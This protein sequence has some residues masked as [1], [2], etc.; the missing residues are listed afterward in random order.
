MAKQINCTEHNGNKEKMNDYQ[1]Q[2]YQGTILRI[3]AVILLVCGAYE[4]L[5]KENNYMLLESSSD[6]FYIWI[7]FGLLLLVLGFV[8][9][10]D[11]KDRIPALEAGVQGEEKVASYLNELSDEYLILNNVSIQAK[12]KQTEI[13]SLVVSRY[14]VWVIET[15]N[16]SGYLTG[17]ANAKKWQRER[18]SQYG[19]I[20]QDEVNN[21]LGQ[22]HR[23]IW[24]LKEVLKAN[25]VYTHIHG[26]VILPSAQQVCVDSDEVVL[27][28][29]DL[30]EEIESERRVNLSDKDLYNILNAFGLQCGE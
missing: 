13:D 28:K 29:E 19:V 11:A 30:L 15:K 18:I 6:H 24:I 9:Q 20:R 14:G 7:I 3:I 5:F 16:Y 4:H 2:I 10:G 1:N 27:D 22:M 25:Y 8:I 26:L 23:Q 21:P 17:S 12:G